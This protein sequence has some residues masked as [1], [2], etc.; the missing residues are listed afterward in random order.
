M[1]NNEIEIPILQ[2]WACEVCSK[3]FVFKEL[4][5]YTRKANKFGSCGF[6]CSKCEQENKGK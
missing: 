4:K 6:R 2:E 1:T 5:L 3:K